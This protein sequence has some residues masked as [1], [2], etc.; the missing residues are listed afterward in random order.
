M[1]VAVAARALVQLLSSKTTPTLWHTKGGCSSSSAAGTKQPLPPLRAL[2]S[3]SLPPSAYTAAAARWLQHCC[4]CCHQGG[5]WTLCCCCCCHQDK[6]W[7]LLLLLLSSGRRE[8]VYIR[9]H[10]FQQHIH[11][12]VCI[13]NSLGHP[14]PPLPVVRVCCHCLG[15]YRCL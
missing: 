11:R 8:G 1:A 14:R 3:L 5:G 7:T 10:L 9:D 13:H 4:C 12:L 15:Q 6:G 2:R